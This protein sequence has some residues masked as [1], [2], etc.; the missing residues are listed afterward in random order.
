MH[1][2]HTAHTTHTTSTRSRHLSAAL[3]ALALVALACGVLLA[4]PR[5]RVF[6]HATLI[7]S[8]PAEESVAP[9]PPSRI[10]LSFAEPVESRLSSI[11]VTT[12]E[13]RRVDRDDLTVQD[14]GRRAV[15][16]LM[17]LERGTYIVDWK[18]V[19]T[20]DG[21]PLSGRFAFHVGER[22]SSALVSKGAST[23]PSPLEPPARFL[24]DAGLLVLAG[25]LG[26]LASVVRP[27]RGGARPEA[28]LYRLAL[29]AAGVVVAGAALQLAAQ[30]SAT[31]AA[32]VD[33]LSGRWGMAYIVRVVAVVLAGGLVLLRRPRLALAP[34]AIALATLA[35]TSHGAA[36]R[37][38]AT[39][40]VIADALHIAAVALWVG[41]LPGVLVVLWTQRGE[42]AEVTAAL[43][44][45]ST[46]A[47]IA[48]GVAG[49][50]GTYLA[51]LHVLRLSAF[52]T[53]YGRAVLAKVALFLGLVVLGAV[54]RRWS[55][56]AL[57]RGGRHRFRL[58]L[59]IEVAFGIGLVAAV[60]VMTSTLPAREALRPA[61]PGGVTTTADGTRIE[62]RARPGLPG[63]NEVTIDVR[64][65]RGRAVAGA[66]VALRAAPLGQQSDAPITAEGSGGGMYRASIVL[67]A[68]GVWNVAVSVAP[69]EGFDTNGAIRL[70]VGGAAPPRP[71]PA[72]AWGWKGL[73]WV[74][75]IGGAFAAAVADREWAWHGRSRSPWYGA[76]AAA[77]GLVVLILVAPRFAEPTSLPPASADTLALGEQVYQANCQRCHGVGLVP[78]EG[79]ADLRMH[80]LM[81][82][83]IYFLDLARNGR[84]GTAM[85][86]FRDTLSEQQ[87]GAVLTYIQEQVR[88]PEASSTPSPL[89]TPAR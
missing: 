42:R 36:V 43:R 56:P 24:L 5:D 1:T 85:P 7:A 4:A 74:L 87:I 33:V 52:D 3:R 50:T 10:T 51:W 71:S 20:I 73:G 39:P 59:G 37:G 79:V 25:T 58:T 27:A 45:F 55:L 31:G 63:A 44:R 84:P 16:S 19:S 41:G 26:V 67:G 23:F 13:G 18:N 15:V 81:H 89:P 48:A 12:T 80:A 14:S 65:S 28:A 30:T 34:A 46:T 49:L 38:L 72:V 69:R 6:A 62:V 40:A 22:S 11:R 76:S 17:P 54:S 78:A 75:I 21:H 66:S 9:L 57:A 2:T 53:T 32:L 88:L 47:L 29:T 70:E 86:P 8:D 61:L 35:A 82:S 64:D 77:A 60:A 83:D 68:R